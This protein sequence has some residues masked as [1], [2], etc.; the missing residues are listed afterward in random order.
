MR[1]SITRCILITIGLHDFVQYH[2][3]PFQVVSHLYVEN[4]QAIGML[5]SIIIVIVMLI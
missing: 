2:L 5:W 3:T 1:K 4:V